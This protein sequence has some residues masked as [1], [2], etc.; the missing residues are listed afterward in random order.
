MADRQLRRYFIEMA[1]AWQR[2]A[3]CGDGEDL[4]QLSS[5][6]SRAFTALEAVRR[7]TLLEPLLGLPSENLLCTRIGPS[8][9]GTLRLLLV[10]ADR[11]EGTAQGLTLACFPADTP[12]HSRLSLKPPELFH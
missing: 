2:V 8:G 5:V 4:V 9:D 3:D 12:T 10:G 6:Q 7:I 1:H 11:V